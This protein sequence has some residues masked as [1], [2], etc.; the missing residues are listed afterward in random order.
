[1]E[2]SQ[3]MADFYQ[4]AQEALAKEP[5]ILTTLGMIPERWRSMTQAALI[6]AYAHGYMQKAVDSRRVQ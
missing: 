2:D 1:M 4:E 5:L 6:V 3:I